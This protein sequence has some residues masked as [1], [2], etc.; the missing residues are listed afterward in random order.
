MRLVSLPGAARLAA[1][2]GPAAFAT[3]EPPL[4]ALSVAGS[5]EVR[6]QP[7]RP[8]VSIGVSVHAPVL[9]TA[10]G[11]SVSAV[12]HVA[13]GGTGLEPPPGLAEIL[14]T[15]NAVRGKWIQSYPLGE[16][17]FHSSVEA[18]F[19]LAAAPVR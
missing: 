9:A 6:A 15:A 14:V 10:A 4:H 7:D 18:S 11:G 12:R 19:E 3:A 5:G 1:L 16:L 13:M 2:P 8:R 17:T